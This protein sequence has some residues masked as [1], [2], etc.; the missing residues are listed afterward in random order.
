[1][2][3]D[4]VELETLYLG[5][6][7][8]AVKVGGVG[9]LFDP[10]NMVDS[11]TMEPLTKCK[12]LIILYTHDHYDHYNAETLKTLAKKLDC[13][14]I[15]E[16]AMTGKLKGIVEAGRLHSAEHGKTLEVE[17]VKVTGIRGRH[18]G[19]IT[20]YLAEAAGV[21]IFHG[22]D[23]G[24]VDLA[25]LSPVDLAILPCGTPSPTASPRDAYRMALDLKPKHVMAVHGS[26]TEMEE[27]GRL[28]TEGLPGVGFTAAKPSG[29]YIFKW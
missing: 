24:Y 15:V 10:A 9:L 14:I 16:P 17:G 4:I 21:R 26:N 19:P 25:K 3:V 13:K 18:V 6:S 23:S 22:G 12:P 7:G 1:M 28:L 8:V 5:Y 2:E 11:K 29:K 27:L 20:L